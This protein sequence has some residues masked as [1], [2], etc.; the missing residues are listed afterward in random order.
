LEQALQE[1]LMANAV[2]MKKKIDKRY[3]SSKGESKREEIREAHRANPMLNTEALV[4][5]NQQRGHHDS[6]NDPSKSKLQKINP[7]LPHTFVPVCVYPWEMVLQ[8]AGNSW[9]RVHDT[10]LHQVPSRF[11]QVMSSSSRQRVAKKGGKGTTIHPM[12]IEWDA[13]LRPKMEYGSVYGLRFDWRLTRN[14]DNIPDDF[15]INA[16]TGVLAQGTNRDSLSSDEQL[17]ESAKHYRRFRAFIKRENRVWY[18]ERGD[19]IQLWLRLHHR[20]SS[21]FGSENSG[22][23]DLANDD[24]SLFQSVFQDTKA[25]KFSG[26]VGKGESQPFFCVR[27]FRVLLR[28]GSSSQET[29]D[30]V[31]LDEDSENATMTFHSVEPLGSFNM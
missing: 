26:N 14:F 12:I 13:K 1:V 22:D 28:N 8:S 29:E 7:V 15:P 5:S 10:V 21:N 20:R 30:G 2:E 16:Q 11:E 3:A 6:S 4:L 17:M 27:G 18:W 9:I 23:G 19:R 24:G 25:N 31:M